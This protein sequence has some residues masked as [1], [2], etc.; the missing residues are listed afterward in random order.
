MSF[1]KLDLKKEDIERVGAYIDYYN[2]L[3]KEEPA[4]SQDAKADYGKA[5]LSL[6]PQAI[7]WDIA[8]I[9]EYGTEKYGDPD[10]WRNVEPQRYVDALLRHISAY[11]SDPDGVDAESGFPHLWHA[12][13]NIAFLLQFEK[14]EKK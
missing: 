3:Y 1:E 9:R 12:A 14:E 6:V 4:S 2:R 5:K 10:N 13:C 7:I 8:A 11:V